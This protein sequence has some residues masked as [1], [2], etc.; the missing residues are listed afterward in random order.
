[1]PP[2]LKVED[3]QPICKIYINFLY[4]LENLFVRNRERERKTE[5]GRN[6]AEEYTV[7]PK[8]QYAIHIIPFQ[9]SITYQRYTVLLN[10]KLKMIAQ[11]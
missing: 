2:E 7:I 9:Y 3:I 10:F 1:M 5:K 4:T 11:S 6:T 8:I